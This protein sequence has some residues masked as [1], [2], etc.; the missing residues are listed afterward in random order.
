VRIGAQ[1]RLTIPEDEMDDAK[2]AP[3]PQRRLAAMPRRTRAVRLVAFM[4]APLIAGAVLYDTG[5]HGLGA[6]LLL[7][8]L[9]FLGLA[10]APA[11]GAQGRHAEREGMVWGKRTEV[12]GFDKPRDHGHLL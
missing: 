7:I 2:P 6:A 11:V 8:G 5:H 9:V 1:Q 10:I 3:S 4:I 12:P